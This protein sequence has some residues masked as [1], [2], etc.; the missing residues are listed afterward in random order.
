MA[1]LHNYKLTV[2]WTG[3]RGTGTSQYRAYDRSHS[4]FVDNKIEIR[5]SSDPA[6]R[7][8]KTLHNPEDLLIA[9][10]SACHMLWYLHVCADAGVIVTAYVD[11]ATGVM[12]E[13]ADGAGFFS[14]V[15][16]NPV[17]TVSENFMAD[18]ANALHKKA[19][20]MCYV[21]N[22]VKFPVHH[23]PV[24]NIAGK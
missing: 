16:L 20:E 8:D 6:F 22:S 24:C 19:N 14:E 23:S 12:V 3:N 2:E 15:H 7:G 4:I 21:A 10:L 9:S 17:V 13:T 18:K 5:G 1:G 11:N